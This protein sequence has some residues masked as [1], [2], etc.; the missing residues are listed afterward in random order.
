MGAAGLLFS[1]TCAPPMYCCSFADI[2]A[3]IVGWAALHREEMCAKATDAFH[4]C[5]HPSSAAVPT[6]F[7]LATY[8]PREY[9]GLCPSAMTV[10]DDSVALVH[11]QWSLNPNTEHI[12]PENSAASRN[13]HTS[14]PAFSVRAFVSSSPS[15]SYVWSGEGGSD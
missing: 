15:S 3:P 11:F 13:A 5:Y 1:C 10:S 4:A 8:V 12:S 7:Q 14:S 9:T 2:G 6:E